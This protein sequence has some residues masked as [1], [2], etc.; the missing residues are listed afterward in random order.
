M[1]PYE[2]PKT[3]P[4][5]PLSTGGSGDDCPRCRSVDVYAPSFTWWGGMLGPRMFN[6]RI[7]RA[8]K[9]GFNAKTRKSNSTAIAI[10]TLIGLGI[11]ILIIAMQSS[12]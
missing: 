7:C 3:S 9:F 11:A 12:R 10:Y 2:A 6:H 5:A 1:N 4:T 8:C